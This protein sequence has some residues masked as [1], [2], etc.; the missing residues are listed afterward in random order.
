MGRRVVFD[1]FGDIDQLH[2][3]EEAPPAASEGEI[4]VRVAFAGLNPVD[5]KILSG[6][7]GPMA[8]DLPSGNGNDFSGV[9]D[10]V[11][12]GVH[13][14]SAGDLVLGGA[15][16][17]AQADHLVVDASQVSHLPAGLG[18]D[19]AG[20]LQI[21]ART[22]VAGIRAIGPAPTDTVFVSGAAGGVGMLA[23]QLARAA[24]AHVIGSASRENHG[25][26]RGLG[27]VPVDYGE[28]M[29]DRLRELAPTGVSAALSTRDLDEVRGLV[30]FGVP[31][32]RIDAIAAGPGAHD[33]GAQTVG[34]AGA[35]PGDLG[36]VAEALARGS[37]VYPIDSVFDLTDVRRAYARLKKGHLRGKILL[38]THAVTEAA[39]VLRG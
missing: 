10:Q 13:G 27:I 11:G 39:D 34:G 9:V 18:L 30:Q 12:P 35:L 36:R 25:F 6:G 31:A 23:A 22:A 33:L 4:R 8:P 26:L 20:G 38:R 2:V 1:H 32:A 37:L 29:W 16:F 14:F 15:R 19:T 21:T 28:G 7:S 3:I 17:L 24:G 5:W